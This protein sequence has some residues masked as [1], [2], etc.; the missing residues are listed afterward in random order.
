MQKSLNHKVCNQNHGGKKWSRL[1]KRW[2]LEGLP[3]HPLASLAFNFIWLA[4]SQITEAPI[5]ACLAW[6][7]LA[8][9]RTILASACCPCVSWSMQQPRQSLE[10]PEGVYRAWHREWQ[11][12]HLAV[13]L[14]AGGELGITPACTRI[15]SSKLEDQKNLRFSSR[16]LIQCQVFRKAGCV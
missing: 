15:N 7:G 9:R 14:W 5:K 10:P 8:G 13:S 1:N 11:N 3:L 2:K 6:T 16:G 4:G 12:C